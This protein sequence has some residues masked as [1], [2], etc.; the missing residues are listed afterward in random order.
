METSN[1][2]RHSQDKDSVNGY[3]PG[4][5]S[6]YQQGAMGEM[7]GAVGG[8][9]QQQ[10]NRQQYH[11]QQQRAVSAPQRSQGAMGGQSG[12]GS[13][14]IRTNIGMTNLMSRDSMSLYDDFAD[15]DPR[16]GSG[17]WVEPVVSSPLR[18]HNESTE[19]GY[20]TRHNRHSQE[21]AAGGTSLGGG[22][23]MSHDSLYEELQNEKQ[24]R[25]VLER[26]SQELQREN[27]MLR[28]SHE[29]K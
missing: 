4:Y 2:L 25:A 28:R 15:D 9:Q 24:R 6:T 5:T 29:S 27:R 19:G 3:N 11:Q 7:K 26:R 13:G 1:I 20:S 14:P 18:Q 21:G 10:Q 17:R 12:G 23:G 22:T 16:G 8:Y